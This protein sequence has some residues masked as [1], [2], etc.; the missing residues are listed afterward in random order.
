MRIKIYWGFERSVVD[1]GIQCMEDYG[2]ATEDVFLSAFRRKG[3][4][5][6]PHAAINS[7]STFRAAVSC[8]CGG[9][10]E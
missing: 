4:T 3:D 8:I 1:M 5:Q 7:A 10:C 6:A 9:T 2:L